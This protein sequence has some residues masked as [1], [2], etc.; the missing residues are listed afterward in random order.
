MEYLVKNEMEEEAK[1][2][3]KV[4][5]RFFYYVNFMCVIPFLK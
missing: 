1:Y 5:S 4:Q 3:L 2:L